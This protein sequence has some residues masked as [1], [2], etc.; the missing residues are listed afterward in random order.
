MRKKII[1]LSV[2]FTYICMFVGAIFIL[3]Y[4]LAI[5]CV[6]ETMKDKYWGIVKPTED[7]LFKKLLFEINYLSARAIEAI[8]R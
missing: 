6:W 7:N 4:F 2:V 8:R 1:I 3:F 5:A